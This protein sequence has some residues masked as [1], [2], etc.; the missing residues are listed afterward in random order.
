[1]H[2][3]ITAEVLAALGAAPAAPPPSPPGHD[4]WFDGTFRKVWGEKN[5]T[6]VIVDHIAIGEIN[7]R[8]AAE[9]SAPL[10]LVPRSL[11]RRVHGGRRQVVTHRQT[12]P[13][14]H[15]APGTSLA[16]RAAA[17]RRAD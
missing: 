7:A 10:H 1:V 16:V 14:R 17:I 5:G 9:V 13:A 3:F 11:Q 12:R 8:A 15:P 6:Q 2:L 4:R